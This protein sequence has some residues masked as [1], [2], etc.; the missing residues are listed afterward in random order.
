MET[1]IKVYDTTSYYL[2]GRYDLR[3]E[4]AKV[5]SKENIEDCKKFVFAMEGIKEDRFIWCEAMTM[6]F[7]LFR[8]VLYYEAMRDE[9]YEELALMKP[10]LEK[11]GKENLELSYKKLQEIENSF[12]I[13]G[14]Q[15]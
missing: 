8:A 10:F 6:P 1:K 15:L 7:P 2:A 5:I 14:L 9:N 12:S 11:D 13:F 3:E 4:I